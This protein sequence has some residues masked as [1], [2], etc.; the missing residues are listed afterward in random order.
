MKLRVQEDGEYH[1]V[2]FEHGRWA[3]QAD[4]GL[5]K[6][7]PWVQDRYGPATSCLGCY[8]GDAS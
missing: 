1:L 4:C 8:G 5:K 3:Q 6:E 2:E 7:G